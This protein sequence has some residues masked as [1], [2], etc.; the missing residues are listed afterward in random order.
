MQGRLSKHPL[1]KRTGTHRDK[2]SLTD[3]FSA[4]NY[5]IEIRENLPHDGI[6]NAVKEV[7]NQ[8]IH[9]DSVIV[10]ILSHG[11]RGTD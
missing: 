6:I 2:T 8:A 1:E 5:L 11:N 4:Y 9:Y 10:S 7:V 3:T